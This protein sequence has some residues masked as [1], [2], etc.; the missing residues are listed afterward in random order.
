MAQETAQN[1]FCEMPVPTVRGNLRTDHSKK[2]HAHTPGRAFVV[3]EENKILSLLMCEILEDTLESYPVFIYAEAG[4][5]KS[6]YVECLYA[7]WLSKHPTKNAVLLTAHDFSRQLNEAFRTKTM[8]EFQRIF[9]HLDF[10]VLEDIHQISSQS[11]TQQEFIYILD[12]LRRR[13]VPVLITSAQAFPQLSLD[14]KLISRLAEGLSVRVHPPQEETRRAILELPQYKKN[15]S[16]TEEAR[17]SL[18]QYTLQAQSTVYEML[19]ELQKLE[20]T[21]RTEKRRKITPQEVHAH[22]ELKQ[23]ENA[24]TLP[25]IARIT[26]KYYKV[27]LNEIRG[28]SRRAT[29][30]IIRNV[31]YYLARKLTPLTLTEIG[32]YFSGRD[33]ATILHGFKY[34]ENQ[35]PV[36]SELHHTVEHLMKRLKSFR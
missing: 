4:L 27:R 3:G 29:F 28:K 2:S 1:S 22:F 7:H 36:N 18:I 13:Q 8:R 19:S 35:L 12:K 31:I 32:E 21:R 30:V 34:V 25:E 17:E 20:M 10:L 24:L 11:F 9:Y 14:T 26:A 33:H 6:H 23:T 5:G 15:Y 16:L